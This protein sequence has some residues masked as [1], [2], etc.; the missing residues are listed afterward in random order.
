[1]AKKVGRRTKTLIIS[2][3]IISVILI[4]SGWSDGV[5][6]ENSVAVVKL[7]GIITSS[8]GDRKSVV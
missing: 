1:M 6:F 5:S 2:L 7:E 4:L 3:I 8:G